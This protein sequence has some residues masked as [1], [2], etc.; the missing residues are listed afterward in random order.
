MAHFDRVIIGAGTSAAVYMCFF[1]VQRGESVLLIG[2]LEPWSKRG[3]HYM[4]QPPHLLMLP[5]AYPVRGARF[6][7]LRSGDGPPDSRAQQAPQAPFLRSDHYA[8]QVRA[9]IGQHF[10]VDGQVTKVTR[11]SRG[12]KIDLLAPLPFDSAAHVPMSVTAGLVVVASGTGD[13]RASRVYKREFDQVEGLFVPGDAYVDESVQVRPGVIAVEG[14]SA[15]AAWAVEKALGARGTQGIV[16]IARV[17]PDREKNTLEQRFGAAFPAGGR[18]NWLLAQAEKITRII[19]NVDRAELIRRSGGVGLKVH[20][21]NGVAIDVDQYV[22][23]IGAEDGGSYLGELR[24]TL[25]PIVDERGHLHVERDAVLGYLSED[26][27]L[28]MVGAA[29]YQLGSKQKYAKSNEYLPRA[30]RPPEGIPTIIATISAL[31]HYIAGGASRWLDLNLASF[32]DLDAHYQSGLARYLSLNIWQGL[33]GFRSP[34]TVEQISRFIT[35]QVIGSR[36]M[37]TS[38]YGVSVE[39]VDTLYEH[40][41]LLA[42]PRRAYHDRSDGVLQGYT[43]MRSLLQ[44]Y[45]S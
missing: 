20:F 45:Y 15:T 31:T 22:A 3:T 2:G 23:A 12:Y 44:A 42:D 29:S 21:T 33:G 30:A 18:N 14:S 1:P 10:R 27:T 4:G 13:P 39:E 36:I 35:D 25:R 32:K 9:I 37:K 19:A 24:A 11:T 16:W 26:R 5:R 43:N 38:P 40:L 8:E 6:P 41:G 34:Y 7:P 28:L 17:D